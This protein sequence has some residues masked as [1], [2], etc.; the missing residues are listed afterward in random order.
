M[1]T[2]LSSIDR[3][4]LQRAI[5]LGK[6]GWGR[7]HPNPLVGCVLVKDGKIISEGW[8]QEFGGPH[9][10]TAALAKAGEEARGSTA[11]VSLEPCNHVGKTPPCARTLAEAGVSRVVFGAGDPGNESAGGGEALRTRGVEVLGPC[12]S[13]AES[14]QEN[15]A[16]FWN[17]ER[18][19]T[20]VSIKLAQT[21]DGKIAEAEGCRTSITG[22][23]AQL[24]THRLRAGFDGV[25]VGS[26]TALVDDPLLTVRRSVPARKQPWRVVLDSR[27]R[28]SPQAKLFRDLPE[29]PLAIFTA[30]DAPR[31][32]VLGLEE[33]GAEV[34]GVP[35]S[36]AGLSISSVLERCWDLGIRSILCEGGGILASGLVREGWCRRIYLFVAPFVLGEKGVPAFQALD[37]RD[38]WEGWEP[39]GLGSRFG[40]DVLLTF[41]RE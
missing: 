40:R 26:R 24:E 14:R 7:V 33:A 36:E 23:E 11:Y 1:D 16:F 29:A 41:D 18:G 5:N 28:V 8:H 15:P 37:S 27:A 30:T 25:L 12:L 2:S 9:A 19:S 4:F 32:S 21:L 20:F 31:A 39:V 17:Q 38:A 35:R 13:P 22:P 10:E 6:R 3:R 34:F